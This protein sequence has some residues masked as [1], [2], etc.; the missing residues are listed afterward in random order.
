MSRAGLALALLSALLALPSTAHSSPAAAAAPAHVAGRAPRSTRYENTRRG[1]THWTAYKNAAPDGAIA[2]Y[3]SAVSVAP[4]ALLQLHISTPY[5]YRVEISRLGWYG[6]SGGRRIACLPSCSSDEQGTAYSIPSPDPTTGELD[7]GWPVTDQV[8]TGRTWTTGYYIAVFL[9]T[10]GP[11]TGKTAFYP[12]VVTPP[13]KLS[14]EILVQVPVNTWQAYNPWPGPTA[15]GKS[16]YASNSAG[17]KAA[18]KVSFNRPLMQQ[19]Q[20]PVFGREY[21]AVRW[22]EKRGYSLGYY[23]DTNVD[24][25]PG[26][27]LK[28]K[29]DMV[30]G[31]DEYW[32]MAMR[33]GWDAARAAG[34]N[35]V[36]LGADIG[37][38]QVRYEDG[39]R[40]LVEYRLAKLD[41]ESDPNLK[42]VMFRNLASP[43]PE[44]ELEGVQYDDHAPHP[45]PF[46]YTVTS[47]GA[48]KPLLRKAG[49]N[50]G[51]TLHNAVGY[52]WDAIVPGCPTPPL[53]DV[54]HLTA[55]AGTSNADAVLF[56]DPS[57]ARVFSVGSNFAPY[58]LD[59][60][61]APSGVKSD[62]RF[63]LFLAALL[64]RML[65]HK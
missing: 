2:G 37:T 36:F 7:A 6:G 50:A 14:T 17:G 29:V 63:Q 60:Y 24:A 19:Y 42:T 38:W 64:K 4:G 32:T 58:L 20:H 55:P 59:S 43:M 8:A 44:C 34:H 39:A 12:F 61:G 62:H 30:L 51:D 57:G 41:P 35:L 16:L 13:R 18:V 23:T 54:F 46:D 21:Q 47:A 52:E 15:G 25:N 48:A 5:R 49:F 53:T 45:H 3:T 9:L 1:D 65:G 11:F 26:L 33:Q 56:R 27:L 28:D 40:T 10:S 22:L 31:H